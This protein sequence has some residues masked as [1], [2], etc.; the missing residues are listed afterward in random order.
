MKSTANS[1]K[2][3]SVARIDISALLPKS[4]KMDDKI[5][6]NLSGARRS[7]ERL[8]KSLDKL[9]ETLKVLESQDKL[10]NFEIQDLMSQFNQAETLTSSVLKKRDDTA[11]S[12]IG[13]I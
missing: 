5:K 7:V 4:A 10:G 3:N 13:K 1:V 6:R 8:R 2:P 9:S 11:S 12:I